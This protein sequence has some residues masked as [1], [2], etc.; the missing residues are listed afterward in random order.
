MKL[1]GYRFTRKLMSILLQIFDQNLLYGTFCVIILAL[2]DL[3]CLHKKIASTDPHPFP[4]FNSV[5]SISDHLRN[6]KT[7]MN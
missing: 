5:Q 2:N 1:T 7:S 6:I 4:D 3:P